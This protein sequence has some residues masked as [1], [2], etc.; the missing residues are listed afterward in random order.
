MYVILSIRYGSMLLAVI[1]FLSCDSYSS[2]RE[3][4]VAILLSIPCILRWRLI[5]VWFNLMVNPLSHF[6]QLS[7]K[8]EKVNI[9]F[10]V[11]SS[12]GIDTWLLAMSRLLLEKGS[13]SL[14]TRFLVADGIMTR[15]MLST[16]MMIWCWNVH[17][18]QY[19]NRET[20]A[21]IDSTRLPYH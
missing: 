6:R 7:P 14:A 15:V 21:K 13:K 8:G 20:C 1:A 9:C 16:H 11:A 4:T 2:I 5:H 18:F 17:V 3:W 19:A 10:I 12:S